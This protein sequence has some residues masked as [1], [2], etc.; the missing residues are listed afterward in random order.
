MQ[1]YMKKKI[2]IYFFT[3]KRGG[4][5]HF[6]PILRQ[7]N[8]SKL[9]K[10]KIIV[11]DM[12]LSNFFGKT[13]DEIQYYT[14]KLILLDKPNKKDTISNRLSVIS[15]TINSL[16]RIFVKK[17]PDFLFLLGD[18]AEVLGAAISGMHFN[19]PIAHMYGGDIT[20]GGTDEQTRH[21]ISKISNLHFTSNF[22]SFKNI[23]KM[24][25]EPWRIFNVGLSSL[26]LFKKKCL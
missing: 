2:T 1:I 11:A 22:H 18:R 5:S 21:A 10:Y 20:Q 8:K 24:G 4:F 14:K 15:K 16:S 26:D 12:H 7:L 9:V 17:K 13:V 25:E 19:I 23:K 3:G 6:V